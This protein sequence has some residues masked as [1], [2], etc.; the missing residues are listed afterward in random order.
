MKSVIDKQIAGSITDRL[1]ENVSRINYGQVAV[2][3]RVHSGRLV[4]IIYTI[5]ESM[6]D[7]GTKEADAGGTYEE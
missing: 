3:L 7:N 4:D 6:R 5:T 2:S 1:L